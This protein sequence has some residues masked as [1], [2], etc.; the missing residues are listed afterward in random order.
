MLMRWGGNLSLASAQALTDLDNDLYRL[1]HPAEEK[2][3]AINN[4]FEDYATAIHNRFKEV[5]D[6][7]TI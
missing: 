6:K 3:T 5:I 2:P 7:P 4:Q 1:E